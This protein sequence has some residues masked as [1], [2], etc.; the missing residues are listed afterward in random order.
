MMPHSTFNDL[1]LVEPILRALAKNEYTQ[2]TDI[3]L[4][5]IPILLNK[6]DLL[7]I[8]QTGTGKTAAFA[9]PILQH[10]FKTQCD[11]TPRTVRT[12]VLAPT[13]ELVIQIADNCKIY[14][15]FLSLRQ[16]TI[17]GGVN[18]KPQIKMMSRGVDLLVATPGRLLDLM[19]QGYVDLSMV[20][21]LVLDEADRM[22]DMGFIKD[23]KKIIAKIPKKRH[24]M[25]FSATMPE[26]ISGLANSILITPKTIEVTPK[27]VTVEKIDQSV[28]MVDKKDKR[29]LLVALF[30]DQTLDKAIV[31][32]KTK[33][34]ANRIV[35]ELDH[36][37]ISSAAIHGNKSQSARQKALAAFK[38]GE[39]RVLVATDIAA[40][41]ID[42]DNISHVINYDLPNEPESY[43]HRI[44][45]TARAGTGG[46]A[47]S[48]CDETEGGLL[49]DIEKVIKFKLT[50]TPTPALERMAPLPNLRPERA[51][52]SDGRFQRNKNQPAFRNSG[53]G[54]PE[55]R[56]QG[57]SSKPKI[58]SQA[59][60]NRRP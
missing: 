38:N 24:T 27:V 54:R 17:F 47:F 8:A 20:T 33:H 10:L 36:A 58:A 45:R 46:T 9:L 13:R 12:L 35:Q 7:G 31:F 18:E 50:V 28:Y 26:S 21:T 56:D 44:G 51:E 57:R 4:N 16:T 42:V 6:E 37:R 53:G 2:P 29:A 48:F 14:G 40:R 25:L 55:G 52:T 34:G 19:E 41:G 39:I 49:R 59:R 43:V 22:L 32:S 3:Q 30:K 23:I 60:N 11:P 15:E 1:G 5:A